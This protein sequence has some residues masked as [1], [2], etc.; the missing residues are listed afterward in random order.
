MDS[1]HTLVD[2]TDPAPD[3][4]R[5]KTEDMHDARGPCIFTV[6]TPPFYLWGMEVL[7]PARQRLVRI[8]YNFLLP[9]TIAWPGKPAQPLR[10][11]LPGWDEL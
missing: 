2:S 3:N 8:Q 1:Q 10:E 5:F 11:W 6:R 4:L 7:G 9:H